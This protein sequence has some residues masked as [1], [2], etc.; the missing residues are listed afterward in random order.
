MSKCLIKLNSQLLDKCH[1]E[2]KQIL[3]L[4]ESNDQIPGV[5]PF[6]ADG[7]MLTEEFIDHQSYPALQ[8]LYQVYPLLRKRVR[9]H[10]HA[11]QEGKRSGL[12]RHVDYCPKADPM[13]GICPASLNFA[14]EGCDDNTPTRWYGWSEWPKLNDFEPRGEVVMSHLNMQSGEVI[15]TSAMQTGG[16]YLFRT[17][18]YHDAHAIELNGVRRV[19]VCIHFLSVLSWDDIV[20]LNKQFISNNI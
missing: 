2:F 10:I 4:L 19:L 7:W 11:N 20:S 5:K 18:R 6:P 14:L 1:F 15:E 16:T 13:F 17:D 12:R 8:E 9:F 3:N